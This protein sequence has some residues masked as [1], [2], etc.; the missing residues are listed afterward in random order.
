M[1]THDSTGPLRILLQ[2]A[3]HVLGTM[4]G[5]RTDNVIAQGAQIGYW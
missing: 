5:G 4:I 3:G 2:I 1:S